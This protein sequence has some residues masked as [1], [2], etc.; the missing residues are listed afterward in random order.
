MNFGW[1]LGMQAS[2]AAGQIR[3]KG[4]DSFR[5]LSRDATIKR[6]YKAKLSAADKT[7]PA[8]KPATRRPSDP[9]PPSEKKAGKLA[10]SDAPS[11]AKAHDSLQALPLLY[12]P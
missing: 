9:L 5:D 2:R 8:P 4:V 11:A 3:A 12:R 10:A 6:S 7:K 1:A